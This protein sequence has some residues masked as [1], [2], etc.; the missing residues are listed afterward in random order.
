MEPPSECSTI[1][2]YAGVHN[3]KY[4]NKIYNHLKECKECDPFYF[5]RAH[6]QREKSDRRFINGTSKTSIKFMI[7]L[8]KTFGPERRD[9]ATIVSWFIINS[10][11]WDAKVQYSRYLSKEETINAI[12]HECTRIARRG[13]LYRRMRWPAWS[14]CNKYYKNGNISGPLKKHKLPDNEIENDKLLEAAAII[15]R[16]TIMDIILHGDS[17]AI[18]HTLEISKVMNG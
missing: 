16:E 11:S 15:G 6:F 13:F 2:Q 12:V 14:Y 4:Y 7:R 5:M 3:Y 8:F 18:M 1:R 9:M 17:K 10:E